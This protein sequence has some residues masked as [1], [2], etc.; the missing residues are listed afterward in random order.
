M[1]R[2]G[3]LDLAHWHKHAGTDRAR[4]RNHAV[5]VPDAEKRATGFGRSARGGC[6]GCSGR[7]SARCGDVDRVWTLSGRRGADKFI[8]KYTDYT[9]S[10][11]E[12]YNI[13]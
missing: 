10:V 4:W 2:V 9:Y 5:K 6:R 7:D 11:I 8:L 1:H 3:R 13:I 12:Q